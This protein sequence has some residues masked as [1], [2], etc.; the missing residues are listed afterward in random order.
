MCDQANSLTQW[1]YLLNIN[2]VDTLIQ[3]QIDEAT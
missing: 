1:E 2:Y 3:N